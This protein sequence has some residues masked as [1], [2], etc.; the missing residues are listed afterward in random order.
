MTEQ[1]CPQCGELFIEHSLTEAAVCL[2]DEIVDLRRQLAQANERADIAIQCTQEAMGLAL[3]R[4]KR[5]DELDA[6]NAR[7][8]MI[9]FAYESVH[10]PVNPLVAE[11]ERLRGA[12]EAIAAKHSGPI[13]HRNFP[14]TTSICEAA[15]AA[16]EASA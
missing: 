5:I 7:L 15:L 13:Q 1:V 11:N 12:L 8:N 16:K 3:D 2:K 4:R 9:C 6:E 10:A 14:S